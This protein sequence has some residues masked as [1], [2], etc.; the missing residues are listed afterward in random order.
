MYAL[1][2]GLEKD[3]W[4]DR[5]IDGGLVDEYVVYG[6]MYLWMEGLIS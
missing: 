1:M 6:L 4:M 5:S 3:G 2:C